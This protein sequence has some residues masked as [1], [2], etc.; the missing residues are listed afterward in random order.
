[1]S[2]GHR[3]EAREQAVREHLNIIAALRTG[4]AQA[5]ADA[6]TRHIRQTAEAAV[7]LMFG[8]PAPRNNAGNHSQN[9]H[10]RAQRGVT[11]VV[12]KTKG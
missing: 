6:M 1:M 3:Y 7:N 10:R 12:R 11:A 2:L 4:N 9:N 8:I 5:A